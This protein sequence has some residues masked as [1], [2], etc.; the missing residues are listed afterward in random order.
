MN[1]I[2]PRIGGDKLQVSKIYV[3]LL[4]RFERPVTLTGNCGNPNEPRDQV[5]VAAA[6]K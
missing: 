2:Y 6:T 5:T 4:Y 1:A 3:I